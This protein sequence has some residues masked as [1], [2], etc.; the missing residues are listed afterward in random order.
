MQSKGK[1]PQVDDQFDD[2]AFAKAFD[3]AHEDLMVVED[4]SSQFANVQDESIEDI[5]EKIEQAASQ[6]LNESNDDLEALGDY[7]PSRIHG[8]DIEMV[9]EGVV[10]A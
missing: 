5:T 8:G 7:N 9:D 6:M 3:Q 2:A 10:H 1:E 4:D